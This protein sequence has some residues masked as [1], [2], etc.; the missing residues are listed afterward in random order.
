MAPA[1]RLVHQQLPQAPLD[2]G[3]GDGRVRQG[4]PHISQHRGVLE[5]GGDREMT[6]VGY[7]V[8][9]LCV[10]IYIYGDVKEYRAPF[11]MFV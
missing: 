4:K 6:V 5:S 1:L 3:Q 10:Y 8:E 2:G 11:V 7:G 9:I